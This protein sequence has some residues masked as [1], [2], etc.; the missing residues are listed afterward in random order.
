MFIRGILSLWCQCPVCVLGGQWLRR[1]SC[2]ALWAYLQSRTDTLLPP[3][4]QITLRFRDCFYFG[5]NGTSRD[6]AT[7][8]SSLHSWVN[9]LAECVL[10]CFLPFFFLMFYF[11]TAFASLKRTL[12]YFFTDLPNVSCLPCSNPTAFAQYQ[13]VLPPSIFQCTMFTTVKHCFVMRK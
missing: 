7:P 10:I 4:L 3:T 12:T 8:S 2:C 5:P 6:N 1:A 11:S 13:T 9:F